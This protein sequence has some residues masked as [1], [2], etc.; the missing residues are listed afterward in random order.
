MSDE[1]GFTLVE[2]L[3][4]EVCVGIAA[5]MVGALLDREVQLVR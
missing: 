1:R 4:V 3:L 5:R 2:V